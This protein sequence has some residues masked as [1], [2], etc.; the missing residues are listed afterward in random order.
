[1]DTIKSFDDIVA[2]LRSLPRRRRVVLACPADSHTEY[3]V[4]RALSEQVADFLFVCDG[5]CRPEFES[6]RRQYSGR[7]EI[8]EE[9]SPDDAA[10]KAVA[11]V[12]EGRAEVLMKGTIN[13]DNL[14]HAVLNK[15]CGLLET[16][17]VLSHVTVTQLPSYNKLLVFSDAAVVP[18]PTL[19]QFDA[20][21]GYAVEV[22]RRIGVAAPKVALINFSEKVSE[23]F[24]HTLAY[25][26]LVHRAIEGRYGEVCV[27]GP[28]DVRTAC[29]AES[30][31]IK[32][33]SSPV[34]GDADV[35][36]FPCIEAGNVF[37]KAITVF[38]GAETAGMLCGTTVPV[39]VASRAD[40]CQ[41]KFYSLAMA[42]LA[43]TD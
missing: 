17:R 13:T 30:G 28:M 29:D 5:K 4:S 3:V 26:E 8:I 11:L 23:K 16:G 42:C 32:G 37:Y 35:L 38:A 19:E 36:I 27:A 41:S 10:R 15:Q 12:R 24:Q 22:S 1:M 2:G 20:I 39:V 18:R 33:I 43:K 31:R 7:V 6:L 9:T 40:S 14:L 25:E 34:V 21:V